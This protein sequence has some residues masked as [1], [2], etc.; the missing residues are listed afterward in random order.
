MRRAVPAKVPVIANFEKNTHRKDEIS[1]ITRRPGGTKGILQSVIHSKPIGP[2]SY[3]NPDPL[4]FAHADVIVAPVVKA[5]G[6]R[7][8]VTGHALR[9]L[10]APAVRQVI[11][12]P[13][14]AESVA[15]Y[16]GFD[17]RIG[18]TAAHG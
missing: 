11:R 10:D 8:R 1:P 9:D 7:V 2:S 5:G 6:F 17:S 12:N 14:R 3:S 15:A 16:R 13:G 4:D 18:S